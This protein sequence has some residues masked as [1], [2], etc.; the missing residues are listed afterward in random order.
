MNKKE[1]EIRKAFEDFKDMSKN[2]VLIGRDRA[3]TEYWAPKKIN[4]E[5]WD[6][7][8]ER[9]K[10]QRRNN[11]IRHWIQLKVELKALPY[12][13]WKYLRKRNL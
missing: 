7:N 13:I 8:E 12:A 9:L 6:L 1:K 10:A 2:N 5:L 3:G 11:V 4:L